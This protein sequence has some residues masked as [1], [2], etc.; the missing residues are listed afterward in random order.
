MD[1]LDDLEFF[2]LFFESSFYQELFIEIFKNK[3]FLLIRNWL[4]ERRTY[5]WLISVDSAKKKYD[6]DYDRY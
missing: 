2:W 5:L 1:Q 6:F 4:T 3:I